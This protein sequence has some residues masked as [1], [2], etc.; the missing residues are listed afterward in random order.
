MPEYAD[1]LF[2]VPCFLLSI[3][4]AKASGV[5]AERKSEKWKTYG[6]IMIISFSIG[7]L[8]MAIL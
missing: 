1:I 5:L 2:A 4:T 6:R 7:V 8:V 3:I